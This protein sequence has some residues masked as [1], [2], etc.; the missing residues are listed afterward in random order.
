MKNSKLKLRITKL[1]KTV[2]IQILEQDKRFVCDGGVGLSFRAKNG[3][4]VYSVKHP[5]I[6]WNAILLRGE[7]SE[8]DDIIF[9]SIFPDNKSRDKF[10]SCLKT[11]LKDWAKNAPEFKKAVK[12]EKVKPKKGSRIFEV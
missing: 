11:A 5:E 1:D 12:P 2:E 7:N 3:L 8:K 6:M 4:L 10:I 9:R